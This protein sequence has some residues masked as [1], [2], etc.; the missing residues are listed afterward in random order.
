MGDGELERKQDLANGTFLN[1]GI[2]FTVYN[3]NQGTERIM[4]FDL[5]PRIK[6]INKARLYRPRAGE[7]DAYPRLSPALTRPIRWGIVEQD[8]TYG[9]PP[10]D[11]IKTSLDNLKTW[12]AV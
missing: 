10:L 4:P 9:T 2:T 11:A 7:P 6:Q 12:G 1:Q 8:Q 3:D 5:L